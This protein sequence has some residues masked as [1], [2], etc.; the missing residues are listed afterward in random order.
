MLMTELRESIKKYNREDL[1]RIIAEMY[2]AM[3]KKLREDKAIDVLLED[4]HAYLNAGKNGG[5]KD[6]PQDFERLNAEIEQFVDYAYNQYYFA[7]NQFVHK[8]ERP[9]W[10]FKVKAYIKELQGISLETQEGGKATDLLQKLYGMLSYACGY[11]LFNT[12]NPFK[13][14]GI[15][16]VEFLNI[17]LKRKFCGGINNEMLKSSINMVVASQVDR[18]TL[19]T[20]LIQI[21]IMNLKSTDAKIMAIEQCKLLK[22]EIEKSSTTSSKKTWSSLNYELEE[23]LNNLVEMIFRIQMELC[24]YDEAIRYF[25]KN[26][27]RR[28]EEVKLYILLR[29]LLEYDLGTYWVREYESAL[30]K[31]VE[32]RDELEMRYQEILAQNQ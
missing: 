19:H 1:H 12:E 30:K 24:E 6:T 11:Y 31:G 16:Q 23:K 25:K 9:K 10:R 32:P 8:N 18:E 2:K 15:E 29:L 26:Y 13:S 7:P 5:K 17:V 20:F 28:D 4:V 3:P 21:L 22:D 14:V 27:V